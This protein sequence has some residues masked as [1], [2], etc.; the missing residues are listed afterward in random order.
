MYTDLF[1]DQ[2]FINIIEKCPS[3]VKAIEYEINGQW[4]AI[5]EEKL[6][7]KAQREKEAYKAGRV[8]NGNSSVDTN[9]SGDYDSDEE[10]TGPSK[11]F[12]FKWI[13][14]NYNRI[15]L[16]SS[17]RQISTTNQDDIPIIELD[18]D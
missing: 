18:D 3:K 12:F 7:R 14:N 10:S 4:K 1:L 11:L 5:T 15:L 8:T 6:S 17:E 9:Q 13:T 16:G 2:F